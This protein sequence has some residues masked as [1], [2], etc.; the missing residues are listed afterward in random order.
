MK[1]YEINLDAWHGY[2]GLFS[3][4]EKAIEILPNCPRFRR[5]LNYLLPN[6]SNSKGVISSPKWEIN[7]KIIPKLELNE[8]KLNILLPD[9]TIEIFKEIYIPE[10][11]EEGKP[12]KKAETKREYVE[13]LY[14]NEPLATAYI[15][16]I[17]IDCIKKD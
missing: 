12:Y 15:R 3:S 14:I 13:T 17:E 11:K 6:Y 7:S 1:I 16:E 5:A 10:I 8:K 2:N 4:I 9:F